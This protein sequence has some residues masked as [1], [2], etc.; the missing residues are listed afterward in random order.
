[1]RELDLTTLLEYLSYDPE[2]GVFMWLK[3]AAQ[4]V[5]VGT[6]PGWT[7]SK[8]YKQVHILG[9]TYPAHRLAWF[10]VYG[11]WPTYTIDHIN[12]IKDD[13]R[14]SNLRDVPQAINNQNHRKAR[15]SSPYIGVYKARDKWRATIRLN[16]K[17][18]HI[19]Y[20]QYP[21]DAHAAYVEAK[22]KLHAGCTI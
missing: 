10:Y 5:K 8:G 18:I 15:Q 21:E 9:R 17:A 11:V 4:C 1:M 12:G 22:R 6:E 2:T 16:G 20:F 19:G 13:N 14:I 3:Q 7:S